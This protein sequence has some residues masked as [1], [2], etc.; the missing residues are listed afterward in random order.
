MAA[1]ASGPERGS[2][3]SL[4]AREPGISKVGR[5]S[6]PWRVWVER[7]TSSWDVLG[8]VANTIDVSSLH[9]F[10]VNNTIL[11]PEIVEW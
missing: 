9:R 3:S 2:S 5:L 10:N 4:W 8:R 11:H 1:Q 7:D 6:W